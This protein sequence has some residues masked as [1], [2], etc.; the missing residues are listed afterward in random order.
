MYITHIIF[1]LDCAGL[2]RP[3][4]FAVVQATGKKKDLPRIGPWAQK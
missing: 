1:L 2:V 4:I 3:L